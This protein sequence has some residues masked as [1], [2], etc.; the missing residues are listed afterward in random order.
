MVDSNISFR[1]IITYA[2]IIAVL[3]VFG[4]PLYWMGISSLKPPT[5]LFNL[6]PELI[7][8]TPTPNNYQELFTRTNYLL[9]LRNSL[10][11]TGG[12]IVIAITLSTLAGY[13][14]TRYKIYQKKNIARAFIFAYM[15]PALMLGL[16]YYLIFSN[17]GLRDTLIGLI[18]AHVSVTLPFTTWIMWQ[19]FQ[20]VPIAWEESAWMMGASRTRTMIEIALP[21]AL[22]G[23]VACTIFAFAVSWNDYTF[24]LLLLQSP[25][26]QVLTTGI[27]QFA[28][29][30]RVEWDLLISGATL[31]VLPPFLIVI[32]LNKYILE[33]FSITGMD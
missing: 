5:E 26:S 21:G 2:L 9:W 14:F 33:G 8:T 10:I 27:D 3:L 22:P 13:G 31:L 16:P 1:Q 32:L 17:L 30:Q 18:L 6:P 20:T 11:V 7:T 23:I 12:T 19:F 24:A 4:F 28:T 15:F 25:Q 29:A